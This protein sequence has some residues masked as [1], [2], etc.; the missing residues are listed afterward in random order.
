MCNR[1]TDE[2]TDRRTDIPSY[3]DARTHLK[4]P[5]GSNPQIDFFLVQ[6]I[7]CICH[8]Y[9]IKSA[10]RGVDSF[11]RL[12]PTGVAMTTSCFILIRC[13]LPTTMLNRC[14][15]DDKLLLSNQVFSDLQQ[16]PTGVAVVTSSF[17]PI[18][19]YLPTTTLAHAA[20]GLR[21]TPCP[22]Q[23]NTGRKRQE[24]GSAS[25]KGL[26]QVL[27]SVSLSVRVCVCVG[28]CVCARVSV[29]ICVCV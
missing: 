2:W 12:R 3:R 11:M 6:H 9:A 4:N 23:R 13:F 22:T 18:R 1:R 8:V 17:I 27:I 20:S 14:C 15:R 5:E 28:L 7:K 29:C 24:S 10:C 21:V 16:C 26:L 19:C 25:T